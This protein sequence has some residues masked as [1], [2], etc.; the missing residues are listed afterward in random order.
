[1]AI[2]VIVRFAARES[3]RLTFDG[4]QRV[5][6]GRGAGSDVR[7]PDRSVSHRHASLRAGAQGGEF[8]LIDEG[9][10]N[11][12]F[13]GDVRISPHTSRIVRSGDM[14]R[15][16]RLWLELKV[17]RGAVVTRDVAALTRDLALALVSQALSAM[18]EDLVT[19]VRVVEGRDQGGVLALVEDGREYV[20]GRA[21]HCDLALADTDAS[22]EHVRLVSR[23]G[24]VFVRDLGAKNGTWIGDAR[25]PEDREV[26]WRPV[27]MVKIGRTVLALEEPVG[28][29]LAAIES[30]ADEPLPP[31]GRIAPPPA[32][33]APPAA[34]VPPPD[35]SARAVPGTPVSVP[36]PRAP[37]LV[38]ASASRWSA[39]DRL[40][41]AAAVGLLA[42]SLAGLVW[43][44]RG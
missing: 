13:I 43:L 9:S 32:P 3:A 31:D 1:M 12:T 19:R 4:T 29:A 22:R 44:L 10:T 36:A 41:M 39:T 38:A 28:D 35:S 37:V 7:L 11:G 15:V 16:G 20:V 17:D 24:A 8:V 34:S 30:A 2:T 5:I 6:I 42:L 27:H 21:P 40:V 14:V 26:P 33:E 23:G 18:G 25:A